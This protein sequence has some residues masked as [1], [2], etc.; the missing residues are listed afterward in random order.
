MEIRKFIIELHPDGNMT[1]CEYEDPEYS[2]KRAYNT[3]LHDVINRLA[4]EV[5]NYTM[6][7]AITDSDKDCA[8]YYASSVTCQKISRI[9]EKM[10]K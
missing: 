5:E 3:A 2:E 1:W 4:L 10:F 7:M 6:M 9:V 8:N